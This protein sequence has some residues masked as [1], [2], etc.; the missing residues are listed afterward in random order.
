MWADG[1]Y[2]GIGTI[3][4]KSRRQSQR[5]VGTLAST[6]S[7]ILASMAGGHKM[8]PVEPQQEDIEDDEISI[9]D[10]GLTSSS[11]EDDSDSPL[12]D[13]REVQES[14][15]EVTHE[16]KPV[17]PERHKLLHKASSNYIDHTP[18]DATP[19][20]TPG[21]ATPGGSRRPFFLRRNKGSTT[22]TGSGD[23]DKAE[24]KKKRKTKK[25]GKEFNFDAESN[26]DVLGIVVMEIKSAADLPK[27]KNCTY[28]FELG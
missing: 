21:V 11:S 1:Q 3:K 19:L 28:S 2:K 26:R 12:E 6:G 18:G 23:S 17:H 20:G 5:A 9:A 4:L 13:E 25:K 27:L 15:D 24:K 10:D 8:V 7:A 22:T 14:P 16:P